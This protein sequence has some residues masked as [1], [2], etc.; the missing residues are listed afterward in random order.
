MFCFCWRFCF[1]CEGKKN[2]NKIK[3][4]K[5]TKYLIWK[6]W[7]VFEIITQPKKNL[8]KNIFV[9]FF[10]FF[11]QHKV[12]QYSNIYVEN[13][14]FFVFIVYIVVVFVLQHILNICLYELLHSF[15]ICINTFVQKAKKILSLLKESLFLF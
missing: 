8:H 6:R 12:F 7:K 15:A 14:F 3:T 4:E 11:L 10:L 13:V 1:S 9:S 5:E 2:I